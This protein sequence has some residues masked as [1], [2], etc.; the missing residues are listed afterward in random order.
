MPRETFSMLP[1]DSLGQRLQGARKAAKKSQAEV[2]AA[3]G[4]HPKTVSRWENDRQTPDPDELAKAAQ[5]LDVEA[6]WLRYGQASGG[7]RTLGDDPGIRALFDSIGAGRS[8]PAA[9]PRQLELMAIDFEREAVLAGA[10][11]P[12]L[13]YARARMRDPELLA[14]FAGGYDE[15]PMTAEEQQVEFETVISE[16]RLN[17]KRR[18]DRLGLGR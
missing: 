17:L 12:F 15:K 2:A 6:D 11:A 3:A 18:I 14:Y 16:L 4:V 10:D 5:F 13:R 1:L 9:L 7:A 8:G